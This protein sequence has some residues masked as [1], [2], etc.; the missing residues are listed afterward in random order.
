MQSIQ[1][2]SQRS[3]IEQR[4]IKLKNDMISLQ[5]SISNM[6]NFMNELLINQKFFIQ[7]NRS[8]KHQISNTFFTSSNRH[9]N[10]IFQ[11]LKSSKF[12]HLQ[13]MS[14]TTKFRTFDVNFFNLNFYITS[15][16]FAENVVNNEKYI[17]YRD[18]IL[19]VQ[20]IKRI[21]RINVENIVFHLHECLKKFVMQ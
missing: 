9:Q 21:V 10:E 18:V 8:A 12:Q 4:L 7:S 14:I 1:I 11:S 2:Q 17:I 3:N 19:F 16:Y 20:Q 5:N 6:Q 15:K 13:V